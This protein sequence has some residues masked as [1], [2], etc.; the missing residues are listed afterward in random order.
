MV[1]FINTIDD[2][3]PNFTLKE[4]SKLLLKVVATKNSAVLELLIRKGANVDGMNAKGAT[5]LHITAF[6]GCTESLQYLIKCG[7]EVNFLTNGAS[8]LDKAMSKKREDCVRILKEAGALSGAEIQSKGVQ[9]GFD[10]EIRQKLYS[11]K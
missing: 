9:N 2:F 5:A 3:D 6:W 7:A 1:G 10:P 8:A 11:N 4:G